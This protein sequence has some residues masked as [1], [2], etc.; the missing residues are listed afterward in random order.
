MTAAHMLALLVPA[1]LIPTRAAGLPKL[2]MFDFEM[3]DTSLED[4]MNGPR[5][6]DWSHCP[7]ALV[8]RVRTGGGEHAGT[9]RGP[10]G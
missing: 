2:A 4:Q 9:D 7:G 5:A 6:D 8:L 10:N 1:S 3:H